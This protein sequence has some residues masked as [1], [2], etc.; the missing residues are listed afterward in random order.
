MERGIYLLISTFI[1][2]IIP[3]YGQFSEDFFRELLVAL[4]PRPTPT[5]EIAAAL[6]EA[7]KCYREGFIGTAYDIYMQYNDYLTPEQHYR[8]G[9]MLD[10]AV[11]SGQS[12][13]PYPPSNDQLAEEEMLKAAEGGHPKAMGAMGWYC[14]YHQK[15]TQEIFAWYEKAVQYGYKSACFNLGLDHF[16]EEQRFHPYYQRDYTQACYWLERAANECY[17]YIAMVIL[18]QIYG[19]DEGKDYQ[20]AAYW[21]QRAYNTEAHPLER[22][23]RAANLVTIYQ[24]YLRDPEKLAYWK[25]KLK[26]YTERLRNL[27]DGL[28]TPEEK[29]HIIWSYTP[30]N[31]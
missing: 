23:Y 15:D 20:K 8:L 22:F 24:D 1:I 27:D 4:A 19:S 18:G 6:S 11:I 12:K 13:P 9:D 14:T 10:S 21:Y 2:G 28:L 5:A 16:L 25:E 3:S 7:D 26:E 30:K 29:E 17:Y 31:N